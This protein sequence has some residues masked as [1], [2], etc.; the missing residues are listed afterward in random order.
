MN[1]QFTTEEQPEAIRTLA[2]DA[3]A[4]TEE[5]TQSEAETVQ[6][7]AI[8]EQMTAD[9]RQVVGSR[10][11]RHNLYA[12]GFVSLILTMPWVIYFLNHFNVT[13]P[14]PY[15]LFSKAAKGYISFVLCCTPLMILFIERKFR[16]RTR[17]MTGIVE[18]I[19]DPRMVG[20]L[21]EMLAIDSLPERRVVKAKL[22]RLLPLLKASDAA[23][24]NGVQREQLNVFVNPELCKPLQRD[25]REIFSRSAR[26]RDIDFQLAIF[27][28]YEQVGDSR[29]IKAVRAVAYPPFGSRR[30][31]P[32]E[33]REEAQRCLT[34]LEMAVE[35]E[36][37]SKLLLRPSSASE[38]MPDTLLR[39]AMHQNTKEQSDS[40][41]RATN[42]PN[43]K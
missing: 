31:V 5:E 13:D 15:P 42:V 16:N 36:T 8:V 27:K 9:I 4:G 25:F 20:P 41:L 14:V 26:Q 23:L 6:Q 28:A 22:T 32:Q 40:L 34:F 17:N 7:S 33:I 29:S 30:G 19:D 2:T 35:K 10:S 11:L 18:T 24:L 43:E 37:A 12:F 21:A 39:P 1:Q 38:I 3:V